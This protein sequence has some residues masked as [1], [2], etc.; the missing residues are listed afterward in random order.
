M[1]PELV[2]RHGVEEI[3]AAVADVLENII[4][5]PSVTVTVHEDLRESM[6]ERLQVVGQN[7]GLGDGLNVI[8]D[9]TLGLSDCRVSWGE[10]GAERNADAIWSRVDDTLDRNFSPFPEEPD[11]E[12][13]N[14]A[15]QA[16]EQIT[17]APDIGTPDGAANDVTPPVEFTNGDP[18]NETLPSPKASAD[19]AAPA[20][21]PDDVLEQSPITIE[22]D[23]ETA[24]DDMN[25]V[26][27]MDANIEPA[28]PENPAPIIMEPPA[29]SAATLE[30]A[31]GG[32]PELPGS[33]TPEHPG[34]ADSGL[35]GVVT[36][37]LPGAVQSVDEDP[38]QENPGPECEPA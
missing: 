16:P 31:D 28:A 29:S 33:I 20:T 22:P 25:A 18:I 38:G 21:P 19:A 8:G 37:G 2:R 10:G 3:E 23:L 27:V 6:A 32:G 1:L 12:E 36:P 14:P 30:P 34:A 5:V 13:P 24:P 26:G 35:P 7:S 11:S 9:P 17:P 15:E 4:D